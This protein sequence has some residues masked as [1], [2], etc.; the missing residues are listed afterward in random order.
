MKSLKRLD[1]RRRRGLE[2]QRQRFTR[3]CKHFKK[4]GIRKVGSDVKKW[5]QFWK[6]SVRPGSPDELQVEYTGDAE[7]LLAE[8][9]LAGPDR[10][11]ITWAQSNIDIIL[12]INPFQGHEIQEGLFALIVPPLKAYFEIHNADRIVKVTSIGKMK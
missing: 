1:H 9:W 11:E 10:T 4:F 8:F 2:S 6:K 3:H 5:R 7:H 12:G